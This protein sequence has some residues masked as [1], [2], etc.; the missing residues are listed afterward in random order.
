MTSSLTDYLSLVSLGSHLNL[1]F[2]EAP[3]LREIEG[4]YD[5]VVWFREKLLPTLPTLRVATFGSSFYC[6]FCFWKADDLKKKK[7]QR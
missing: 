6:W 1:G 2:G 3:A 7:K 5:A 4:V